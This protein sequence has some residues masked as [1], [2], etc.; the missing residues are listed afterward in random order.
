MNLNPNAAGLSARQKINFDFKHFFWVFV[1]L[2]VL[3][4]ASVVST[5]GQAKD[6]EKKPPQS[7]NEPKVDIKVNRHYDNK[8]NIIGYDSTYSSF[9]SNIHGDTVGMHSMMKNFDRH[10]SNIHSPLFGKDFDK[11]FLYDTTGVHDF[12]TGD[13]FHPDFFMNQDKCHGIFDDLTRQM[14]SLKNR[15]FDEEVHK[16][17][18]KR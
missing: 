10:F 6:F 7:G 2:M 4:L 1:M 11:M 15:F 5:S 13:F 16:F 12:F 9:Y 14:D 3:I 8:G 18:H 17:R